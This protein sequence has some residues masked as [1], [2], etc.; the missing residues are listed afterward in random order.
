MLFGTPGSGLSF[1][2]DPTG[3]TEETGTTDDPAD[4]PLTRFLGQSV[5]SVGA[6]EY[7]DGRTAFTA[8]LA[9]GFEGGRVRLLGLDG[10]LLDGR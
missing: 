9:L 7:R 4:L 5:R 6:V 1:R 3:A 2:A 10:A 8:G